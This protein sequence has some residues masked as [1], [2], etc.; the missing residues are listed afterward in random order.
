MHNY[1]T[2]ETDKN[3]VL[4]DQPFVD[5]EDIE[6]VVKNKFEVLYTATKSTDDILI[7]HKMLKN[8]YKMKTNEI[9]QYFN[10]NKY[11][12]ISLNPKIT[13]RFYLAK[14]NKNE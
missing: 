9:P 12:K 6:F 10:L 4:W 8:G 7:I 2:I 13:V 14:E 1:T 5:D 11:K 3:T